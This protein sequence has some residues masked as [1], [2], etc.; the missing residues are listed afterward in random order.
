MRRGFGWIL[1][2]LVA[3]RR[4]IGQG[5]VALLLATVGSLAAG[6][7]LG[8]ITGTL[9]RLPGLMILVP[10]AVAT[11][12]NIFGAL[13]SRLGTSIHT[14]L[15]ETGRAREGVLYQ[16]VFAATVLTLAVSLAVA[17]LA[18]AFAEAFGISSIS[19]VDF[20][21][22]SLVGGILASIFVGA[23]AIALALQAYRRGW[24]LDTVSA[25]LITAAGDMF[26]IPALYLA[27]FLVGIRWVSGGLAVALTIATL[28]LL[29][30][31][32]TTHLPTARRV[33]RESLPVLVLAGSVDIMAGLVVQARLAE[34]V[35]LPALLILIPPILG[36]A[37]GLGGLLSSRLASK[38]HL[39]VLTPRGRPEAVALLDAAVVMMIALLVFP[40]LGVAAEVLALV[41]D[42]QSPGLP[43]MVTVAVIAGLMAT[44]LA[45]LVAYYSAVATYR[46]GLD[47]D[48]H[49]IPMITS[50]MDFAGVLSL[51]VA[52]GAA[53]VV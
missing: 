37:G 49:G 44:A 31:G 16:N 17:V 24:D 20:V 36:N 10:A 1:S 33:L 50:S 29:V 52:L 19:F 34:F 6:V 21:V 28:V 25:P 53:G 27:S 4:T 7:V 26:T 35:A 8:L 12:G 46:L 32:L 15:F 45:L 9:E 3:E 40:L 13:G 23:F 11:R 14:G 41:L 5:F 48:N 22:I 38:L 39:G 42:L 18:K 47:P 30:L 43:R 51:V 2:F